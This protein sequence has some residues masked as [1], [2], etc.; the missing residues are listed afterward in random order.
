M[1]SQK[2][3]TILIP[4]YKTLDLTKVCL[5][6]LKINTN[7]NFVD[8]VVIDNNS[9]DD[10]TTY[11]K[12]LKWI[13]YIHRKGDVDEGGPMSHA[14]ALD[15]ALKQIKTPFVLSFHTDTFVI[16]KGWLD[17][18]LK[19]FENKNVAGVGSWKLEQKTTLK[20]LGKKIEINIKKIFKLKV[21][22]QRID[23]NYYYLR[24]HCAIYRMKYLKKVKSCFSDENESAGKIL[25]RKL[26]EADYDMVF[27][28]SNILGKFI[29][30]INHVT[31]G[32]NREFGIRSSTKVVR[33]YFN[34]MNKKEIQVVL[35]NN[36]LDN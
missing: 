12:K 11:L 8:I 34:Y 20:R 1:S 14:R 10:S 9:Q 6:L 29:H 19:P 16:K 32:V 25:H 7:L 2:L 5:R 31:Q 4:H 13:K 23:K 22:K 33:N 35:N 3:V 36:D 24:S 17:V 28:E 15:L 21:N 30:H 27:L 18:L 26:T